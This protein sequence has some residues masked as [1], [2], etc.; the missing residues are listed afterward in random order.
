MT[1]RLL[2][3]ALGK[4]HFWLMLIGFNLTFF[5]MHILGMDGMPRRIYRYPPGMGWDFL[6]FLETI[7][8]FIIALSIVVFIVNVIRTRS[9]G[10]I[11]GADPWDART[12]EW[13]IPSP[14]PPYN[15]EEIPVVRSVDALWHR[16]YV[17]RED[18][19]PVPVVAGGS[20]GVDGM[21]PPVA[22]ADDGAVSYEE[23]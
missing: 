9:R 8:A 5:P 12:L 19:R 14:P 10:A 3:E 13:S 1:G 4:L 22:G 20:D 17:E 2:S 7:G 18:G 11:A 6:N 23:H 21:H 15:F 16:K